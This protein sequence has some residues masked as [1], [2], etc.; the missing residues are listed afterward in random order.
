MRT[1]VAIVGGGC[2]AMTAA[3][4]L[5]RPHLRERY[6]VD[7]YQ[8]GWRL[9]GKGASG[10]G[11][12]GR[13]E[14]HG[15]H[16]WMG[17]YENA[18]R[19][20]REAYEERG[21][22]PRDCPIATWRDAFM[23][24][25]HVGLANSSEGDDSIWTAIFP[26]LPG[27]PGDPLD[28]RS[29]NPFTFAGY[30]GR[31][32][33]VMRT[34][35]RVAWGPQFESALEWVPPHPIAR[36][37]PIAE[38]LATSGGVAATLVEG[39]ARLLGWLSSLV[40]VGTHG[41]LSHVSILLEAVQS[42]IVSVRQQVS[43][44]S[45]AVRAFEV[46][47]VVTAA[48]LGTLRAGVATNPAGFD[49]LDGYDF[50]DWLRANGASSAA[51]NCTFV[52][53]LYSLMFAFEDGDPQRPRAA[54]GQALR[55]CLRMFFTYRGAFFWKMCGG[56]GDVVF[57]P[58]YEVLVRRGVRFHFFHRATNIEMSPAGCGSNHVSA[59]EFDLQARC[60][61]EYAP[62]TTIRGMQAWPAEPFWDQLEDGETLRRHGV[63]FE[64]FHD[65]HR[66]ATKTLHV[67]VDFDIV[68]LAVGLGAV[69]HLCREILDREPRW[70][71][72]TAS[73]K[74]VATQALQVWSGASLSELGWNRSS[75]TLTSFVHPFD[76]WADMSHL[77]HR[78][79]WPKE[80]EPR[81]IAYFCNVLADA[82][83]G[84]ITSVSTTAS[85]RAHVF[86]AA[87]KFVELDLPKLWPALAGDPWSALVDWR[88]DK[89]LGVERLEAQFWTANVNP[90]DRYTLC[91]P[92]TPS[93]RISPLDR[94]IDNL[95]V[96]GDW[97]SCGLSLG[98]VES[99]V[100]SGMLAAHAVTGSSPPL[101]AIIGYD[102]P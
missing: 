85:A 50:I 64:C 84:P 71:A 91:L 75:V 69:P 42:L 12:N 54:A 33:D 60:R 97:T 27:E 57:A 95:T 10:R 65:P 68:V 18:F 83:I 67:G 36:R 53:G 37:D 102:H 1:R 44:G 59:V 11:P 30:L 35:F 100:M 96:A 28:E 39:M 5:S 26:T 62:L 19:L 7:V 55:G 88:S 86:H 74:T 14:E 47:E 52:R 34:L 45:H 4:E 31:T 90:T 21:L 43:R 8:V 63:D 2:A 6:E 23:P 87:Q 61:R 76:T 78:E 94:T 56:M 51:A 22:G 58:L 13:I 92:G 77:I 99:A 66:V 3:F 20:M 49:V 79:D 15:L 38:V 72:M 93:L 24:T 40:R 80:T 41:V 9:G 25:G 29:G 98:C 48:L 16:I 89:T 73:M 70:R 46:L 82:E 81:S 17:F 101:S 32:V